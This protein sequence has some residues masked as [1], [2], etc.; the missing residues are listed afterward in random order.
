MDMTS[1]S[2]SWP[3]AVAS[4]FI[5]STIYIIHCYS[6]YLKDPSFM[7]V[8]SYVYHHKLCSS[9]YNL[10]KHFIYILQK[11]SRSRYIEMPSRLQPILASI[12]QFQIAKIIQLKICSLIDF[13]S[14]IKWLPSY[15]Y[16]YSSRGTNPELTPS[17]V[18]YQPD[19][20]TSTESTDRSLNSNVL[21]L[22]DLAVPTA[23]R[24][25]CFERLKDK[26]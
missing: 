18:V 9:Q 22:F 25:A 3:Q 16:F 26:I 24:T 8:V 5:V 4:Q 19:L 15:F 13:T 6:T 20:P 11:N 17:N 1:H 12:Y 7:I 14:M 10:Q 2:E 21:R 23:W